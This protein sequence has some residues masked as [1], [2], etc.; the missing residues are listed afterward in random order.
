LFGACKFE[1][2]HREKKNTN[3]NPFAHKNRSLEK[4][5]SEKKMFFP[6]VIFIWGKSTHAKL[7]KFYD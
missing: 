1:S 6:V 3:E 5:E 4:R 7:I 2:K